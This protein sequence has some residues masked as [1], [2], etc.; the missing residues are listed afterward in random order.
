MDVAENLIIGGTLSVATLAPTEIAAAG[1]SG[2]ALILRNDEVQTGGDLFSIEGTA[3]QSALRVVAGNT[4][5]GGALAVDG[6]AAL[7]ALPDAN[8]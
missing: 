4:R 3:G 8:Q 6:A 2:G 1:S 7:C 5:L